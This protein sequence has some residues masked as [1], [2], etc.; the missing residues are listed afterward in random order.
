MVAHYPTVGAAMHEISQEEIALCETEEEIV[1]S[2]SFAC[3]H[4]YRKC[5]DAKHCVISDEARSSRERQKFCVHG[6]I[7]ARQS[8]ASNEHEYQTQF[9]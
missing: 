9:S 1:N 3:C 8:G 5:S 7:G 2:P 4:L 6:I